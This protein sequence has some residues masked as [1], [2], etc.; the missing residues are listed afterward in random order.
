MLKQFKNIKVIISLNTF[1]DK[2]RENFEKYST[3]KDRLIT[4]KKL[5]KEGIYTILNISP[6]FPYITN[7]QDI[8]KETKEYVDEYYFEFLTLAKDYKREVLKIIKD[9]Y[10][11]YY[12]NY[13]EIYLFNNNEYF[14]NLKKEI[15]EF[16][17]KNKIK[18][19]FPSKN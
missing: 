13:A 5:H 14:L 12:L 3:I 16:C 17:L 10:E 4:I 6:I 2:F 9:K 11:K 7:Y 8:I 19:Y 15:E 18:C 1:D